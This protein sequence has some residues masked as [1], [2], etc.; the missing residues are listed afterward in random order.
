MRLF[1]WFLV[2]A[3]S[4]STVAL[5]ANGVKH[6]KN[7]EKTEKSTTT[8]TETPTGAGPASIMM[9]TDPDVE[10]FNTNLAVSNFGVDRS[11]VIGLR[12]SGWS[13]GDILLMSNI[14]NRSKQPLLTIAN[15]RSTGMSYD[16]IGAKYNLT[17]Y[18]ITTP[19]LI[20]TRVAGFVSEYGYQPL[21]YK[22]DPWGNP[23][24]TRF[25]A[26]RLSRMGY[27]WRDIAIAAN[28]ASMSG[29]NIND[30]LAW[31]NRGYTWQQIA[32]EYGLDTNKIMDVSQ[33]PFAKETSAT[34]T[35]ATMTTTTPPTGAG[36]SATTSTTTTTTTEPSVPPNY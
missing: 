19:A 8:T 2:L 33:Y 11:S 29:A 36:P 30:V 20:Q 13:W 27:D 32:L 25:D 1:K 15:M 24:L 4:L 3:L 26:M 31:T 23:V 9:Q 7:E 5:F 17:T 18:D 35:S 22:T 14:A 10:A 21:Y 6:E 16:A 28:V 34:M 12:Q